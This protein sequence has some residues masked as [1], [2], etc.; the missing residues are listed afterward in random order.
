MA[1]QGVSDKQLI[2]VLLRERDELYCRAVK[3]NGD[4]SYALRRAGEDVQLKP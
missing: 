3:V 4:R 1:V 2:E